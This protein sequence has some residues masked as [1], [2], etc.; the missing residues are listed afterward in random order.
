MR[1]AVAAVGLGLAA[2]ALAGTVVGRVDVLDRG[3]RRLGDLSDVVVYV[4]GVKARPRPGHATVTMKGKAFTPRVL[5]VGVGTTVDFPN[6]D[7]I[8][9]NVFSVSGDN[10]FDLELYKR[11]RS[12]SWTFQHPGWIDAMKE[13]TL[14]KQDGLIGHLGTTNFDTD[15]LRLLHDHG[16]PILTNQACFSLLD[17]RAH[18][19]M[20]AFCATA[21]VKLLAYGT[22]AGGLLTGKWHGRARPTQVSD[23][24]TMKY[25]RFVEA[26]GGW[27]ALQEILNAAAKVAAK[28]GVS[29]GNV[30]TRWVLEQK[31]VAGIIIGARLGER[32]HRG[33]NLKVFQFTLDEEDYRLVD[34]ALAQTKA[35][36]SRM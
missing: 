27:E 25:L 2:P 36:P 16:I 10:R 32:E 3:G 8:F 19:E 24:S 34:A 5:A 9:H 1:S 35:I 30:A 14:A 28:H 29:I 20:S 15:H 13:L 4:E 33:D 11:P 7:P 17:R 12:G 31:M 21:G 23:W 6:E 26:I 18:G 22:L